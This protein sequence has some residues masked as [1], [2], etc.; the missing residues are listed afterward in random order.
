LYGK[1]TV[2]ER[3]RV[4]PAS[5]RKIY[6]QEGV[7]E[8]AWVRKR[9]KPVGIPVWV[10]PPS[11]ILKIARNKNTQGIVAE[12]DPFDYRPYGDL[13][14]TAR[15]KNRT[16]V[17]LDRLQDPQNL[18][19]IIR[20][21]ACLGRFSLVLPRH[22]SVEITE[23]V[24]RVA[25]GGDNYVPVARVANLVQA[26]KEAKEEGF[27]IAGSVIK[28][29]E[30]LG[31]VTLPHPL[32]LVVGSEHKGVRPI[33]QK[34]LD[35]KLTIPMA[36]ETVTFNAA[37]AAAILCYEINRQKRVYRRERQGDGSGD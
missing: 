34:H 36:A 16:L 27:C 37:Q 21:L 3:L 19:G 14:V 26:I 1:N 5:V 11:K 29:G 6:I 23:T 4:S 32:G 13:L 20:T 30:P 35:V 28:E 22:D 10:V 7:R 12:V 31:E 9:V 24:L 18:G 33:V 25:S 17:F 2:I 15:Q 8:T